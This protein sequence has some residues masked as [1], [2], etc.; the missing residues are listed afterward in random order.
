LRVQSTPSGSHHTPTTKYKIGARG[1]NPEDRF[2][3][4]FTEPPSSFSLAHIHFFEFFQPSTYVA[5][6][7]KI[8]K[9]FVK[10]Y[11]KK[12]IQKEAF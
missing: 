12:L 5:N 11:F 10:H 3:L 2:G 9:V 7:K 1:S 4:G 8:N 6:L